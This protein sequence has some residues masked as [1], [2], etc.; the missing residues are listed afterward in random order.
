MII[1]RRDMSDQSFGQRTIFACSICEGIQWRVGEVDPPYVFYVCATCDHRMGMS[2]ATDAAQ[3]N[4]RSFG[5]DL[6]AYTRA[7]IAQ[8]ELLCAETKRL[9]EQQRQLARSLALGW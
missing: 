9:G 2:Y 3:D 8:S 5:G 7:L 1:T 4:Q 6:C